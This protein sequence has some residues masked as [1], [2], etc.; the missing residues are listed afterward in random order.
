MKNPNQIKEQFIVVGCKTTI[1]GY[2]VSRRP[3]LRNAWFRRFSTKQEKAYALL[4]KIECAEYN[5]KIRVRRGKN[6]PDE[7]DD[8][9]SSVN[10]GIKGWKR[11]SK[12]KHQYLNVR[13]SSE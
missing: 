7:W 1:F 11:N 5:V 12:R 8:L 3:Y 10:Y 9:R 6:L 4:H 13:T 2:C